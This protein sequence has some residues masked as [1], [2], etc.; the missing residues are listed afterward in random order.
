MASLSTAERGTE[1][2]IAND[3]VE[4]LNA[5][6]SPFHCVDEIKKRLTANGFSELDERRPWA[7]LVKAG[8]KYFVSR[9]GS[10]LI[11]FAVGGASASSTIARPRG[12][13][14]SWRPRTA[15]SADRRA[16]REAQGGG[17]GHE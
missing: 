16:R 8:G 7:P 17:A 14:T 13:D 11:A 9:N 3:F 12:T 4:Y 2:E 5:A 15:V 10:S 1:T 6:Q